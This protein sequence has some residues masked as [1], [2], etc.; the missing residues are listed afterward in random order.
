MTRLI[1]DVRA[2]LDTTG[3]TVEARILVNDFKAQMAA[4]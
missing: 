3:L 4:A 2:T 1:D